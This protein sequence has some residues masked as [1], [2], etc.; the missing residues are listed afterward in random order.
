MKV[1]EHLPGTFA[2][3]TLWI[4]LMK[5]VK[6]LQQASEVVS[7]PC[8]SKKCNLSDAEEVLASSRVLIFPL[9]DFFS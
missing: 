3:G 1:A 2:T 9:F 7:A 8:S 4:S 6:W 5:G